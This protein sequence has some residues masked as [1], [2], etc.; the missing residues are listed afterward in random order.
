MRP[1]PA[2]RAASTLVLCLLLPGV[3]H[4]RQWPS[5]NLSVTFDSFPNRNQTFEARARL[6]VEDAYEPTSNLRVTLSGFAEGLLALRETVGQSRASVSDAVVHPHDAHVRLTFGSLD[7]LAGYARVV[8]GRLDELQPTDVVNP[9]DVSRFFFEGRGEARLPVALGRARFSL[10]ENASIEGVYV[11]FFRRGRW[12]QLDEDTSPFNLTAGAPDDQVV[13]LAIGCPVLA[14]RDR[15]SPAFTIRNAQGGVRVSATAR[16][17]DWSVSAYRGFEPIGVLV[18]LPAQGT[19]VDISET[20]PR[21][22][23]FGGDFETVSGEWGL[24]GEIAVFTE[25]SFQSV[26]LRRIGGRSLDAGFGVDRRAGDY[27]IH[28]TVLVHSEWYDLPLDERGAASR[29]DV[30]L[31][32]SAD[33]TFARE[34]YRLRAFGVYNASETSGFVRSIGIVTLKDN[35]ALEG[36]VGWFVGEGRDVIGRFAEND[37][38]YARVKYYF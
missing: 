33:R 8:W 21:F 9:L 20:Y 17:V 23:M 1:S 3:V 22:T 6:F 38:A 11:P 27:T 31:I 2:R 29:S 12:D 36:S 30:S 35:L 13:C 18:A 19:V 14:R 16:R 24:R 26:L 4:A 28:A 7:L 34:R 5:G 15:V 10:A 32:A 37:F 25:D